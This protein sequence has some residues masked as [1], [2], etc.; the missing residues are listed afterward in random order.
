MDQTGVATLHNTYKTTT[1]GRQQQ[2]L[3]K[4]RTFL[5]GEQ[6]W[7][8]CRVQDC[9]AT[10][11]LVLKM[12]SSSSPETKRPAPTTLQ[13]W[14]PRSRRDKND[15]SSSPR[16]SQVSPF[17]TPQS[18]EKSG[19]P[20]LSELG[21][22]GTHQ[23]RKAPVEGP[24][25]SRTRKTVP[26]LTAPI[27]KVL[28]FPMNEGRDGLLTKNDDRPP[29]APHLGFEWVRETSGRWRERK[30]RF[31]RKSRKGGSSDQNSSDVSLGSESGGIPHISI[32]PL[33]DCASN[34]PMAARDRPLDLL[35]PVASHSPNNFCS[36]DSKP[37]GRLRDKEGLVG[38][39]KRMFKDHLRRP[40]SAASY[41][42]DYTATKMTNATG[43][44][45][46]KAASFLHTLQDDKTRSKVRSLT[47]SDK[48]ISS[49]SRDGLSTSG[50]SREARGFRLPA[51]KSPA[52]STSS[53]IWQ[54]MIG[55][56]PVNTPNPEA[57]YGTKNNSSEYFKVELADP[58][59]PTFLPS[60]ARRV[61]TPPLPSDRPR[62][63]KPRGFFFDYSP[64]GGGK[65][66]VS[67]IDNEAPQAAE[68][69]KATSESK[70]WYSVRMDAEEAMHETN[71]DFDLNVPEHLPGSPLCPQSLMHSSGGKGICVYH[72]RRRDSRL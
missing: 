35:L 70:D 15:L 33:A 68:R 31:R 71:L 11:R 37:S 9:D 38:R 42:V 10:L 59:G 23:M 60:E 8:L 7:Q 16:H 51:R 43:L 14:P 2:I 5:K 47:S 25:P 30:E 45:L 46:S 66:P 63:G 34:E 53:S 62:R 1:L 4:T 36:A 32:L 40:D 67:D 48:T 20:Q 52:M 41:K 29:R 56:P 24:P 50:S 28:R 27:S 57:L 44:V 64:P 21:S 39:S 72:G 58:D 19:H 22:L 13:S 69:N 65:G 61:G 26:L 12:H 55:K 49:S 6:A 17:S 54:V 18:L 3:N